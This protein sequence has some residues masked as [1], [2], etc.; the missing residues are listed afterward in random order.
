MD[1][2]L[3]ADGIEVR[4]G[5]AAVLRGVNLAV[6]AGEVLGVFGP[7][8]AGK[9]TLFR[10]LAGEERLAAGRVVLVGAD[11]TA[12]P[13]WERARRGL[14]YVPQ[15]PS[16][17]LDLTVAENLTVFQQLSP[18]RADRAVAARAAAQLLE[19]LGLAGRAG[20]RAGALSGGERRRLEL[21]RA[22]SA[23]PRV[24]LCDEPFAAIDPHGAER[25]GARIRALADAGAA[26]LLADHHVAEALRLCDRAAL[27]L[28][29]EIALV[30]APADFCRDP[31][32]QQHYAVVQRVHAGGWGRPPE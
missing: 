1:A 13:L 31:L 25:A 15:T 12:R 23:E 8:G 4:L 2:L 7:S 5:G 16:V 27:L 24:L 9:S 26:V 30:A 28:G 20:V 21:A 19:E 22:L 14:G 11:V 17:L 29:G 18:R 6:A 32:V 10:A 3:V